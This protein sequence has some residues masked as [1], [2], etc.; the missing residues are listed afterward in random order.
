MQYLKFHQ[1]IAPQKFLCQVE[2]FEYHRQHFCSSKAVERENIY[3][4][5]STVHMGV[6]YLF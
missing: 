4:K 2:N 6:T 3:S 1:S 5:Q